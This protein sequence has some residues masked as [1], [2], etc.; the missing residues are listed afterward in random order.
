MLIFTISESSGA[1]S[2]CLSVYTEVSTVPARSP[3]DAGSA[4]T[5]SRID[6]GIPL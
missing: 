3:P 6:G 5:T 1:I 4:T 2:S